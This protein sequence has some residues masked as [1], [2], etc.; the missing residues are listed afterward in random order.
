MAEIVVREVQASRRPKV[1]PL[2][3]EAVRKARQTAHLHPHREVLALN[4]GRAG[5]A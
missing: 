4:M 1:L 3:A 2:L 5:A